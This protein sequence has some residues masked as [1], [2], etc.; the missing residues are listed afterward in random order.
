MSIAL[1]RFSSLIVLSAVLGGCGGGSDEPA[2]PVT[3]TPPVKE[4]PPYAIP[5]HLRIPAYESRTD[6]YF[7]VEPAYPYFFGVGSSWAPSVRYTDATAAISVSVVGATI[8]MQVSGHEFWTG[9]FTLPSALTRL[10]PG[11]FKELRSPGQD[12]GRGALSLEGAIPG[13]C[14]GGTADWLII[15]KV[16]YENDVV[17][18]LD[19]RFEED[20]PRDGFAPQSTQGTLRWTL[21]HANA[22]KPIGPAPIPPDLI[23]PQ[24]PPP[25][26]TGN[27]VNLSASN[28]AGMDGPFGL[29]TASNAQIA[30]TGVEGGVEIEIK[31]AYP[32]LGKF[33]M[34]AP[35]K[36][37]QV[38]YY[39]NIGPGPV[40]NSRLG[41]LNWKNDTWH[42][43]NMTGSAAI[44]KV[45]YV[46][47]Q[48]TE[49]DMLFSHF[50]NHKAGRSM[51]G[52]VRWRAG[53]L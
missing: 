36:Q 50:C 24:T 40:F 10:Q 12:P 20:C 39:P 43:L 11:Y 41:G 48:I 22:V 45:T 21:A 13:A 46:G 38:G 44:K 5:E 53:S 35:Y 33:M 9:E 52:E 2:T 30:V 14:Q 31:G 49:L 8:K 47:D 18:E 42:C 1:V 6:N 34:M 4:A 28:V 17:T 25:P 37:V 29:Y 7:G 27:F 51:S 15:D 32:W 19:L 3:P 26:A 23:G 16:T